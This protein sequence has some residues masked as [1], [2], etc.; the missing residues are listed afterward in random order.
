MTLH[1]EIDPDAAFFIPRVEGPTIAQ[2]FW[3]PGVEEQ[4]DSGF[5]SSY[6]SVLMQ[7]PRKFFYANLERLRPEGLDGVGVTP[8]SR[9]LLRGWLM[10]ACMQVYY[11]GQ[12]T[13]AAKLEAYERLNAVGKIPVYADLVEEVEVLWTAYLDRYKVEDAQFLEPLAVEHPLHVREIDDGQEF[14]YT[15]RADAIMR[16]KRTGLIWVYEHKNLSTFGEDQRESYFFD[17]QVQGEAWTYAKN[18]PQTPFGGVI[19]NIVVCTKKPS[20]YRLAVTFTDGQLRN[21][22]TQMRAW[23]LTE[24][25]FKALNWPQNFASCKT[26]YPGA[27]GGNCDYH[28]LCRTQTRMSDI[29]GKAA[30]MGF[31]RRERLVRKESLT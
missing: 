15:I 21:F 19:V 18:F 22:G 7:C 28:T 13:D 10:H 17:L 4:Q 2:A 27:R 30:P 6:H 14:I 24:S 23:A 1:D 3:G 29:R 9:S 26:K 16:D 8:R 31:V 5:G 12:Q 20:F 11:G 25:V